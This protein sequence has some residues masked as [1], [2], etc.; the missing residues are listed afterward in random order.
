M[1]PFGCSIEGPRIVRSYLQLVLTASATGLAELVSCRSAVE[2][3]RGRKI[4]DAFL[5]ESRKIYR[6]KL[7][8]AATH[9]PFLPPNVPG[10]AAATPA[11]GGV[12][13]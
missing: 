6:V 9:P 11:A 1:K 13:C 7:R 10:V 2:N 4:V 8:D 5:P 12:Y 3:K